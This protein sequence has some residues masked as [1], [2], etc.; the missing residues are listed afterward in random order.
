MS[1]NTVSAVTTHVLDAARG[2]PASGVAVRLESVG[3]SGPTKLAEA[4]TD[5]D[6][7]AKQLGPERLEAGDYRLTFATGAY[8]EGLGTES[9]YPQVQITFRIGDPEQ[10][11][12]VPLLLSPFSYSTYRGS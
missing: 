7:R 8:F 5:G 4:V 6:G 11:H 12:H 3:E 10:H 9:F 1:T 2:L